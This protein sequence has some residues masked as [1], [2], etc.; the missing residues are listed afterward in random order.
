[1]SIILETLNSTTTGDTVIFQNMEMA[2]LL[3][4]SNTN[5]GYITL[6]EALNS[7]TARITETSE[8][9]TVPEL[10]RYNSR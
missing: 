8:D 2:P 6:D 1:M 5:F 7:G 9:G 10:L 3:A 4:D